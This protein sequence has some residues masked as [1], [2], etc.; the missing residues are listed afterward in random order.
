MHYLGCGIVP[1]RFYWAPHYMQMSS[2]S[3]ILAAAFASGNA[4][5]SSRRV[6]Y[7][8]GACFTLSAGNEVLASKFNM[9]PRW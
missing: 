2:V 9:S 6:L 7:F 1:R 5:V 3:G 4:D 8:L